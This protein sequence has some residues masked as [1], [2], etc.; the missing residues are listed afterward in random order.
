MA[1]IGHEL[2]HT[3][4]VIAEPSVRSDAEKYFLYQRIGMRG[5][6]GTSETMAAMDAGNAVRAEVEKFNRQAK[7]E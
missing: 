5:V 1:S 3:V 2:R 7:S 4:E 6:T